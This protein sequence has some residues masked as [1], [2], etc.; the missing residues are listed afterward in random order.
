MTLQPSG[1]EA[2]VAYLSEAPAPVTRKKVEK[3]LKVNKGSLD[4]AAASGR[5]FAWPKYRGAERYWHRNPAVVVREAVVSV[6]AG[7]ALAKKDLVAKAA[8]LSFNCP[9]K[10]VEA[11]VA[12]LVRDGAVKTAKPVGPGALF[13]SPAHPE[14]LVR[15]AHEMVDERLRRAGVDTG[16]RAAEFVPAPAPLSEPAPPPAASLEE[17][18]LDV[19]RRLQP[20]PAVPVTVQSIRAAVPDAGKK[21]VDQAI[22]ALA[23]RQKVFL[24]AH[25]HGWA[26]PE[27][28]R[29]ELVFDGGQKLYVAVTLRD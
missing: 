15:S 19:V 10:V 24:T 21:S 7:A 16:L 20:A 17:R 4:E 3:D 25:D 9:K 22:L 5:L 23:D 29:E 12:A 8:K 2:I 11:A 18:I 26:L 27:A 14:A 28:Q 1:M 6:L 13:Y